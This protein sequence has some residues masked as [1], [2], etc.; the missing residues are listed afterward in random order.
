MENQ[1]LLEYSF[2]G[3]RT[4]F[5]RSGPACVFCGL[6]SLLQCLIFVDGS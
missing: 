2:L 6:F 4:V 3:A 5:V 1:G